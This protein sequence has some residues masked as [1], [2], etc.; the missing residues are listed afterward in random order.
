MEVT[1]KKLIGL[2]KCDTRIR[3]IQ[4]Q[5]EKGP[6]DIKR[7]EDELEVMMNQLDEA[8]NRFEDFERQKREVEREIAEFGGSLESSNM[9]L[10][11][12]KSNKEYQAALKEISDLE[13]QKSRLEDKAIEIMEEIEALEGACATAEAE[14]KRLKKRCTEGCNLIRKELK[15]LDQDLEDLEKEREHLC[16]SIDEELLKKYDYLREHKDGLA[17]SSVVN[18]V[19]QTCHMGIPPQK[20]NELIRGNELMGCPNCLRI[21]Y[22]GEDERLQDVI[23]G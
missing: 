13:K 11:N 23:N 12:I 21:M 17:I 18:G 6:A 15:T 2:Q 8:S 19:C 4:A 5:K 20:F 3:E 7:L 1:I 10:S 14:R 9:K 16:R 22:W